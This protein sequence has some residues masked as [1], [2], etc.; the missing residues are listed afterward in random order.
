MAVITLGAALPLLLPHQTAIARVVNDSWSAVMSLPKE[1]LIILDATARANIMSCHMRYRA[2][3]YFETVGVHTRDLNRA[4]F[5]VIEDKI[6][7]RFKK[8][9]EDLQSS[10][11]LTTQVSTIREQLPLEGIGNV[12]FV[13]V[14]YVLDD[15]CQ[16]IDR[17]CAVCMYGDRNFW[18]YDLSSGTELGNVQKLFPPTEFEELDSQ[19][20]GKPDALK[21]RRGD[22]SDENKS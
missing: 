14:G 3:A 20:I 9:D 1:H 18:E 21:Q 12:S 10:N 16:N 7:I 2:T 11:V 8:F 6:A 22:V 13:D 17:I 19:I 4:K 15:Q 5:Y